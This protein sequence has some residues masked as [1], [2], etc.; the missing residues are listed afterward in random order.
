[1]RPSV[2]AI[3]VVAA[4]ALVSCAS[5]PSAAPA[6]PAGRTPWIF[7]D[8]GLEEAPLAMLEIAKRDNPGVSVA[9]ASG[10]AFGRVAWFNSLLDQ[11]ELH[12]R[13]GLEAKIALYDA[14]FGYLPAAPT[15]DF[16]RMAAIGG[17]FGEGKPLVLYAKAYQPSAKA[18]AG[19]GVV[20]QYTGNFVVVRDNKTGEVRRNPVNGMISPG[21]NWFTNGIVFADGRVVKTSYLYDPEEEKATAAEGGPAMVKA[22]LADLRVKDELLD[23]DAGIEASL[24][25]A[26]AD[27]AA[28][29]NIRALAKLNLFMFGLYAGDLAKAEAALDAARA[30]GA[31]ITEPSF[32][33]VIDLQAP[34]MLAVYRHAVGAK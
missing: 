29:V 21:F 17:Y 27:P 5:A 9:A 11:L 6:A 32:R 7:S 22:N 20:I 18:P 24:E 23:N 28:D 3:L 13:L 2:P 10:A 4:L 15:A 12:D 1:M 14:L 8:G 16:Y 30:V 34:A 19:S 33:E 25:E 31:S 26:F